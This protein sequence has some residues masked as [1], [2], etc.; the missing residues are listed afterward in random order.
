[1][2][3]PAGHRRARGCGVERGASPRGRP[4]WS[5]RSSGTAATKRAS[6]QEGPCGS[7]RPAI[8]WSPSGSPG[9]GRAATTT[10]LATQAAGGNVPDL[11]QIDD[12]M[13]G[14]YA[15]RGIVL[16]LGG[17]A[18]DSRINLNDLCPPGLVDYGKIDGRTTAYRPRR[19]RPGRGVQPGPAPP[20]QGARAATSD[21]L[22]RLPDWAARVT[23]ASGGRVAGSMDPSGRPPGAVALAARVGHQVLPGYA[24]WV[25]AR[26]AI[27]WTGSSLGRAPG[28]RR[29][30][31][32]AAWSI[33]RTAASR[34]RQ[35]VVT[36]HTAASF[37]WSHQ[38]P[39]LQRLYRGRLGAGGFPG[40]RAA[41]WERASMYWAGFRGTRQPG[42]RGRERDQLPD[43]ERRGRPWSLRSPNGASAPNLG[44]RRSSRRPLDDA[45]QQ[46]A[47]HPRVRGA[48]ADA[49]P[50]RP[51]RPRKGHGEVRD[52]LARGGPEHPVAGRSGMRRGG[53][54]VHGRGPGRP[55]RG[56]HEPELTTSAAGLHH[57]VRVLTGQRGGRLRRLR[58]SSTTSRTMPPTTTRQQ[59]SPGRARPRRANA[60]GRLHH[61]FTGAGGRPGGH[62]HED[63]QRTAPRT[64]LRRPHHLLQKSCPHP[65]PSAQPPPAS[66]PADWYARPTAV[67]FAPLLN[68]PLRSFSLA[69]R[70]NQA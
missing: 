70:P 29:A 16:D 30:T 12:T 4:G 40:P 22:G 63:R 55:G 11:F 38:F 54:T 68:N 50:R 19:P 52:L 5:C 9:R 27:C 58:I 57:P 32:A 23:R 1:M 64:A 20:A 34:D 51:P 2:G 28:S 45:G 56:D 24:S 67:A 43:N 60:A 41:Q 35:L 39:E 13:L 18:E 8:R 21:D 44:A 17:Y 7:T 33:G 42:E 53:R 25:S 36:G 69:G 49:R 31:P 66:Q 26:A 6:H 37:A 48:P 62:R 15:Q 65:L 46:R 3:L 47:R 61:Q 59:S 10:E 14:E